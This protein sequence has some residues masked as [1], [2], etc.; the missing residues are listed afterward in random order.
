MTTKN[1]HDRGLVLRGL[2]AAMLAAQ[3]RIVDAGPARARRV[4][5]VRL[6]LL[7]ELLHW[8]NRWVPDESP[9]LDVLDHPTPEEVEHVNDGLE[10]VLSGLAT[11]GNTFDP[12][13]ALTTALA[14]LGL[15]PALEATMRS[16]KAEVRH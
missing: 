7:V 16:S 12:E 9:E 14:Q 6:D 5:E 15:G 11:I 4:P 8:T 1:G 3:R 2:L 13:G 10:L